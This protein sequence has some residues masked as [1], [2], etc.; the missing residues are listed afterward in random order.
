MDYSF[1]LKASG[2]VFRESL[3]AVLIYGIIVS[4]F[5]KSSGTTKETNAAKLGLVLGIVASILLGFAFAGV[6]PL[7]STE[8]YALI[9]IGIIFGGSLL[10]LY[11]V[12]WMAE[13]SRTLKKDIESSLSQALSAHSLKAITGTVF[14]AVVREGVETVIYLYSLSLENSSATHRSS[15]LISLGLGVGLSFLVYQLMIHGSKFL[16]TPVI[17]KITGTWLLF[18]SS[19]LIATGFDKLFSAGYFEK[20]SQS[21]FSFEPGGLLLSVSNFFESI[22]GLRFQPSPLH[23]ASFAVFWVFV[24]YKDPLNYRKN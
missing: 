1:L 14:V 10:M 11:M 18:S 9:E 8:S 12:F 3:E 5:R 7:I 15:I 6:T 23:L 4:F 19:S 21:V 24:I 17:F 20:A 13:H 2:I 22:I 16:S